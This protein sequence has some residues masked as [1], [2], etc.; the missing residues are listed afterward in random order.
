M[1]SIPL[2]TRD[3]VMR[4]ESANGGESMQN[5]NGMDGSRRNSHVG[6]RS[7]GGSRNLADFAGNSLW[8]ID[9]D[10]LS[11]F[12]FVRGD[13]CPDERFITG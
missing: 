6:R 12:V 2:A 1:N 5:S 10:G 7:E 13:I 4:S 3:I 8:S 9:F 11:H